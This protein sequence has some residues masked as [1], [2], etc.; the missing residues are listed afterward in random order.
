MLI[1]NSLRAGV[2]SRLGYAAQLATVRYLGRFFADVS[3]LPATAA[4]ALARQLGLSDASSIAEYQNS[5][6]RLRHTEEI[7]HTYGYREITTAYAGFRLSRWLYVQCWTGTDRPT[8]LFDRATSWLLAHKVLLPG[9]SVLERFVARVRQRVEQRIWRLISQGIGAESQRKLEA[10]LLVPEG[11]RHTWFDQLRKS[12]VSMSGPSLVRALDRLDKVRAHGIALRAGASIPASRIAALANFASRAKAVA[13]ARLPKVRRLAA[14]AAFMHTLDASAQDD[15]LDVLDGLLN[16]I[17]RTAERADKNARLRSLRDLDAA[18]STLV[19]VCA[20]LLDTALADGEVRAKVFD[21]F[22]RDA[23][24]TTLNEAY[25]LVRPQDD[26]YYRELNEAHRRVR[27]FLPR[28]LETITFDAGPAGESVAVALAYLRQH[29]HQRQFDD[30][31]PLAVINAS[32]R[33]HVLPAAQNG[34][35][36]PRAYTFCVLDQLRAALKRRDVFVMPSWRYADPRIGLLSGAEWATARPTI[37]RTLAL[38]ADP[39]PVLDALAHELDQTYRSV[40]QRL[41][42]NPAVRFAGVRGKETIVLSALEKLDESASLLNLRAAI[43]ERMPRV[44]LP[45]IL[46]E[47]AAR[48][49]FTTSFSH[50]SEKSAR[51]S[52]LE[53]SLCAVLIAEA[54]NTGVVPLAREDVAA[55]TRDRLT[56]VAQNYVRDETLVAANAM[57]VAAQSALSL[58]Q[59]W[60][61]G[62]VASADGMRFVVPV[63]TVHAGP[64]PKYFGVGRGVTYYN[65][66]SDQFTGLHAITVPGTLRD[67]LVLLSVVLEQETELQPTQ[68]MTD[69]GAYSDVVFGLFRLLGF[70]FCPRLADVGGTRFWRIDSSADY[71]ALNGIAR[72]RINLDLIARHWDDLLRL[73]GSLRLGKVSPAAIMRTLQ[74]GDRPTRL[75]QALAEFGRI[76][77]TLHM[78]NYID[79]EDK[80]RATLIQLNRGEGHHS[81]AREVFHGQRGELRQRYRDGQED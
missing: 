29:P 62:E 30:T 42:N 26:V 50:M 48:T 28:L 72:Q 6:Q 11:H 80:R 63:K 10:L 67:S 13:I 52:G 68:I 24:Q 22:S 55:L 3:E 19:E 20:V 59:R 2:A 16:E 66:V 5:R 27:L 61:G 56:W 33:P 15:A 74:T 71:G 38:D 49:N 47:I 18:A 34:T 76:D 21:R 65:L 8:V 78:L 39:R 1:G 79:D 17:F 23:L 25:A 14:L 73:A 37:C 58:A 7:C 51:A 32:W 43:A 40:V 36:D 53:T 35:I 75:A 12:P 69:T 64:N 31:V 45:E 46:L 54:C 77:K 4:S 60:G 57:L 70:R 44:D 81:V 9:A 41:P